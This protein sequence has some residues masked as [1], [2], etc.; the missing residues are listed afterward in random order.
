MTI[1]YKVFYYYHSS[2]VRI[3]PLGTATTIGLLYHPGMI[4]NGD[5]GAIGG[6]KIGR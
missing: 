5:C 6:M 2:G 4:N 1:K 3:S